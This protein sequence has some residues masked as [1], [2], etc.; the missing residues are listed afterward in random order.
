MMELLYWYQ[1]QWLVHQ[2]VMDTC[3]L[4]CRVIGAGEKRNLGLAE[5]DCFEFLCWHRLFLIFGGFRAWSDQ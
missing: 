2:R 1:C 3:L 5:V 4:I